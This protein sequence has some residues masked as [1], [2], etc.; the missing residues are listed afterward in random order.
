MGLWADAT[1]FKRMRDDLP[2]VVL[3]TSV[4]VDGRITLGRERLL[5]DPQVEARWSTMAVPGAFEA[6][7]ALV[8]RGRRARSGRLDVHR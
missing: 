4:S 8:R 7:H 2:E 6:R 5:L 1:R 3:T